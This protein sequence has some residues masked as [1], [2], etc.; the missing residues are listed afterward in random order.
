[1]S[2]RK[3]EFNE[4]GIQV[5]WLEPEH[6]KNAFEFAMAHCSKS[7][8][9]L[10]ERKVSNIIKHKASSDAVAT[11]WLEENFV[12]DGTVQIIYDA[13]DV[14]VASATDLLTHWNEIFLP[15]RDDALVLHN[16]SRL[17]LFYC[18]EEVIEIGER[19]ER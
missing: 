2:Y 18:H 5:R 11:A 16:L 6:A 19:K 7:P 12:S 17:I 4:L 10:S 1:M 3:R 14:C 9:G 8:F 15:A 13:K